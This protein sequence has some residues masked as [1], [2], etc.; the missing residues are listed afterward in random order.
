MELMAGLAITGILFVG[1]HALLNQLGDARDR[2]VAEA[3]RAD[4]AANASR[5]LHDLLHDAQAG[6]D[7]VDRFNGDDRQASFVSWCRA[8]GG[9]LERCHVELTLVP[10]GD[11]TTMVGVIENIGGFR[12]WTGP[13][14]A[15]FLYFTPSM[16]DDTW[17]SAW[18]RSIAAPS[19]VGVATDSYL[20]V[21]GAGGR[22]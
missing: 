10:S 13:G 17:V 9:W 1:I 20:M 21:L 18:G 4:G 7:S 16:P 22:G 19:A 14:D 3:Q 6:T 15:H 11:S 2:F 5:M 12:M 8:P